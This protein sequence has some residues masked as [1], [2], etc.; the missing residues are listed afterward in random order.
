MRRHISHTIISL[1][2]SATPTPSPTQR[3]LTTI[4][5]KPKNITFNPQQQ[6]ILTSISNSK[7]VFI[8]GPAGTGKTV[9]L[10][11]AIKILRQK[12]QRSEVY[13]TAS[14]GVAA[15][16][17]NGQTIHSFAGLGLS[18]KEPLGEDELKVMIGR[19]F[20]NK[21]AV[22]R[23]RRVKALVI[24]EV[25]MVNGH[26]FDNLEY[27]ARKIRGDWKPWGKIQL[28]VSG[29]F[30]QLAPITNEEKED[31]K[32]FAFEADCW[33]F[34]FDLQ[35][36]LTEVFRQQ[37][38]QCLIDLLHAVRKGRVDDDHIRVLEQ[39]CDKPFDESMNV[40]HIFPLNNEVN[41]FNEKRLRKLGGDVQKYTA[42]DTGKEPWKSQLQ[43][44]IAPDELE[45]CAGARVMLTKNKDSYRGLVNGATGTVVDF[46]LVRDEKK[47]KK[48]KGVSATGWLPKVK[49]DSGPLIVVEPQSW[50]IQE[51]SS[52]VATRKQ[53]PLMLAWAVSAHKCQG[54]TLDC[55]RTDLSRAFG[56]GMVYVVISRVRS[57]EGL[58]LSGFDSSKIKAHPKVVDFYENVLC[59]I[60]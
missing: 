55:L 40:T 35:V 11:E 33:N 4:T 32:A 2:L 7:N 6:H 51:G 30:F 28:I 23:W 22:M 24:D 58:H 19:I 37:S 57:L 44:G 25:S 41:K 31:E 50:S 47:M 10:Q 5:K 14:T 20:K 9:L 36:E 34:S 15:F 21:R 29:D 38:D 1:K 12:Y 3:T 39:C 18:A 53:V 52:K 27:I 42:K 59:R 49:F 13:V 60:A 46:V 8:T 26:F 17:L 54:M 56:Y 45:L 16:H 48:L 43:K